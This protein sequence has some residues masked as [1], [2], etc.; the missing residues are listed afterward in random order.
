MF[1]AQTQQIINMDLLELSKKEIQEL[2][3]VSAMEVVDG[4]NEDVLKAYLFAKSKVEY[5]TAFAKG[6][7]DTAIEEFEAY[8]EKEV[9][10]RDRRISK[11]ETGVKYDYSNCGHVNLDALE[12]VNKDVL[13][14]IK[15]FQTQIKYISGSQTMVDEDGEVFTVIPPTKKSTT[16]LKLTY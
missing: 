10:I 3:T 8:S 12:R 2:G 14:K 13:D 11:V 1:K 7:H 4:G 15:A 6:L 9:R 16:S 5:Y